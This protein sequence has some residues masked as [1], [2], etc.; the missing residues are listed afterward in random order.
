[1]EEATSNTGIHP[2][3][4]LEPEPVPCAGP[5]GVQPLRWHASGG[6]PALSLV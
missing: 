2:V 5:S 1:M 6:G 3:L 4:L